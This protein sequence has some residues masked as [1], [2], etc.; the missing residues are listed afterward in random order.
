MRKAILIVLVAITAPVFSQQ[1]TPIRQV[2]IVEVIADPGKF[3]DKFIQLSGFFEYDGGGNG[4]IFLSK[5]DAKY[6]ITKNGLLIKFKNSYLEK[7]DPGRYNRQYVK[8]SADFNK[9]GSGMLAQFSGTLYEAEKLISLEEAYIERE[10]R[11]I[12]ETKD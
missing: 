6:G 3:D 5:D 4:R 1:P 7:H 12:P 11:K 8:I 10:F 9:E 2:S